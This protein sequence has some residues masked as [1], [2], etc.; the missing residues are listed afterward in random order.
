MV[1]SSDLWAVSKLASMK[2]ATQAL[3][4]YLISSHTLGKIATPDVTSKTLTGQQP[5]KSSTIWNMVSHAAEF[6]CQ[7]ARLPF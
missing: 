1:G 3:Y 4:E 6:P 7:A 5:G 2:P